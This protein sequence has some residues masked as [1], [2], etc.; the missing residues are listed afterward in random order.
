M[1]TH[2]KTFLRR[3]DGVA[4][5]EFALMFPIMIGLFMC[6]AEMGAIQMRQAMLE[7]AM[8][9]VVRD[10]RLGKPEYRDPNALKAAVCAEALVLTDCETNMSLEMGPVV[11]R[12]FTYWEG[13]AECIDRSLPVNPVTTFKAGANN[14]IML[15]RFCYMHDPIFPAVGLGKALPPVVNGGYKMM[16]S[17]FFVNEPT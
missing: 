15:I 3:D 12:G 1:I 16:A 6:S 4:T 14:E 9:I 5:I 7:R 2:L 8:D 13:G 17:T 10:L 11:T